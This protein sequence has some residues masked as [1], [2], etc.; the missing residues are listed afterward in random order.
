MMSRLR[1]RTIALKEVRHILRDWQTLVVVLVMPVMMMFLYGYALN[2]DAKEIPVMIELPS[3]GPEARTMADKIDASQLFAVKGI[4]NAASDPAELFKLHGIKA[5]FR[6]PPGFARELRRAGGARVQVLIDGSDP[7]LGTIIRNA[8]EPMLMGATLE[9]LN[10]RQPKV[11]D[12]RTLILYNP[13]QR[14][15]LF[16]V[17]G[18]MAIILLM[19]SALLTSVAVAREKELGTMG[20][21]LVSPLHPLEIIVGK[22]IPYV[23]LA[24][25]D[26]FLVLAVGRIAFGVRIA[27]NPWFLGLCSLA[28][29]FTALSI[30][31]LISTLV[32]RQQHAMFAALGATMMPTVLLSG[33]IFPVISMPLPLRI[34]SHIIPA[35]YFLE[36]VRGVILKGVGL[37]ELWAPLLILC[38][39]GIALMSVAIRK[40]KVKL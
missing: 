18:L 23:F 3:P 33:F 16:F 4:V 2:A 5:L 32:K 29:I 12:L 39:E 34:I 20:Q 31:L 9:V 28:Y 24:A 26:G 13:E 1:I 7:N 37:R 27:G 25:V 40:F 35:T 14:S 17:P 30:G 8:A 10:A 11:L 15:A 21:L 38:A 36:I 22:I 19:I 6:F